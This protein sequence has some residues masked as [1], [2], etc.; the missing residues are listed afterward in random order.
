MSFKIEDLSSTEKKA[1]FDI[2]AK[3]VAKSFNGV[4]KLFQKDADLKGFRKG[5]VPLKVVE[6]IYASQIDEEI[7]TRII[8]DN[9]RKLA[10]EEKINIVKTSNLEF[11]DFNKEKNFEFSFNFEFIPEIK[12]SEYKSMEVEKEIFS[13]EQK[14][15]D[16]AIENLLINFATN[17][18]VPKRKKIQKKDI[19]SINFSGKVGDKIIKDLV[20]ENALI[21]LGNDSLIPDIEAEIK[22]M[23]LG[24]EKNFDVTYPSEFPIAEAAGKIVNCTVIINK[25]YKKVIP[26]LDDDFMK[27]LGIESKEMLEERVASDLERSCNEK[28]EGS[29]RRNIGDKLISDNNFEFPKSFLTDEEKRLENEYLARMNEKGIKTEE[30]DSKTKGVIKESA[31][32]NVK[33]ALIFAEISKVEN[34]LVDDN[35]IEQVIASIAKSQ[36]TQISKVKKYYKDNNLMDDVKVKLTDEKVIRFLV[37]EAKI[38]EIKPKT[39]K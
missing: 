7:K 25:I 9:L 18:E 8:N 23:T 15:I 26:E 34:I 35:E 17:E 22:N 19:L 31:E 6:S 14:D 2:D 4:V 29:L 12:L 21:E 32:R 37:S 10:L 1:L 11:K 24:E 39:A 36:N 30:V 5:K 20:R 38:K 13:I 28:S 16:K 33:L 3:E 27:K